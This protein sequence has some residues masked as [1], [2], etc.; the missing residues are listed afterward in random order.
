[1]EAPF[2]GEWH[3]LTYVLDTCYSNSKVE[4]GFLGDKTGSQVEWCEDSSNIHIKNGK[5]C[6]CRR[7]GD[8][9][10]D[11]RTIQPLLLG[12]AGRG[13]EKSQQ[14]LLDFWLGRQGGR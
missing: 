9:G 5:D 2:S 8:R 3:D 10:I 6:T 13:R 14:Y 12:E 11:L 7:D 4:D 1:M